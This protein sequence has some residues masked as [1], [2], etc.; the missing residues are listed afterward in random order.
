MRRSSPGW[1]EQ[2]E[3]F[4]KI[5]E[6][7]VSSPVLQAPKVGNPFNMYIVMQE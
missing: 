5:E 6:Y 7:L 1:A 4:E 2:R 3:A